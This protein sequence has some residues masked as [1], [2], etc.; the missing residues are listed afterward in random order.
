M[1]SPFDAQSGKDMQAYQRLGTQEP[2]CAQCDETDPHA[3][4]G[5]EPNILCSACRCKCR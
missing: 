4:T 3:L 2:Q 1:K 5:R